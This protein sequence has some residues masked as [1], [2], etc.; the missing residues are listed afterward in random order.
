M[1]SKNTSTVVGTIPP[2]QDKQNTVEIFEEGRRL[3]FYSA[4]GAAEKIGCSVALVSRMATQGRLRVLVSADGK[5][6]MIL[7]HDVES[8]ARD[9]A[10]K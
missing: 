3:R 4:T 5:T 1:S 2:G 7:A 6:R 8:I 9:R 10:K